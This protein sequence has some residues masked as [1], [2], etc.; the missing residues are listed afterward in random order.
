MPI[1][2]LRNEQ[3]AQRLRN[4][5][6]TDFERDL[7]ETLLAW[8]WRYKAPLELIKRTA[9]VCLDADEGKI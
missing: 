1:L 7:V 8:R 5:A 6:T 2:A 4:Y 3:D 9:E